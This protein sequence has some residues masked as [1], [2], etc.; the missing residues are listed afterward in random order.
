MAILA[1]IG[2]GPSIDLFHPEDFE[3][4]IGVNDIWSRHPVPAVVCVDH[5]NAFTPQRLAVIEN[6]RPSVF[7]TQMNCWEHK[8]GY[9]KITIEPGYPDLIC[10][11]DQ[12][13]FQ[14]S[15]CSPFIACQIA[16]RYYDAE[17]IHLFGVDMT[18]HPHLDRALCDKIKIHFTNLQRAL[19]AAGSR[20]I[21]HGDGILTNLCQ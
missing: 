6:C 11:L 4:T 8:P 21:P 20:I 14:K 16:Y 7:Y 3:M 2:L 1:V 5:R 9:K 15:F 18:N 10:R 13:G 12:I 17:E 19:L